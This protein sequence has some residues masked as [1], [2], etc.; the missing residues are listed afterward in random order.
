VTRKVQNLFE[1]V[2]KFGERNS[3]GGDESQCKNLFS[4]LGLTESICFKMF[5]QYFN[6]S[7]TLIDG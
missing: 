7:F 1:K 4:L 5:E 2:F 6:I 3:G